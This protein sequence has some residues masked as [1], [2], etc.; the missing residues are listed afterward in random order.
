MTDQFILDGHEP[1]PC[2]DLFEWGRWLQ[3]AERKGASDTVGD[4]RV[5]TVFL[6]LEHS[7]GEGPPVLF[8]TMVFGG[9]LSDEMDRYCTWDEAEAGHAAMVR[10]VRNSQSTPTADTEAP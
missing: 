2:D 4:V 8:E 3:T 1:V 7:F 10:R 9:T 5:S 6:G